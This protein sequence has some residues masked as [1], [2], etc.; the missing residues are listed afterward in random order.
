MRYALMLAVMTAMVLPL[1][2]NRTVDPWGG[3]NP[4]GNLVLHR[5]DGSHLLSATL[6]SA[7]SARLVD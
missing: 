2:P 1:L 7:Y 6:R 4:V 5:S 3:L